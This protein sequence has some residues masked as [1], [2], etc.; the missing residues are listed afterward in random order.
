MGHGR[1]AIV[2][3]V[4]V[5][6]LQTFHKIQVRVVRELEKKFSG[7]HV[8]VIGQRRILKKETRKTRVKQPRPRSR[9]LTAVHDAILDDLVYPVEITGKR[10]RVKLDTSKTLKAYVHFSFSVLSSL[11]A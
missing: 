8:L 3:F 4:P 6:L 5:P 10:I 9:T 1:K 11:A 7:K 2:M